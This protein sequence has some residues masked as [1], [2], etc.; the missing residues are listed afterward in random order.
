MKRVRRPG[1]PREELGGW[2]VRAQTEGKA[3]TAE[4]GLKWVR[5]KGFGVD[6]NAWQ[7]AWR[8]EG[9]KEKQVHRPGIPREELGGWVVRAQTEGG[10]KTAE[11]GLKWVQG[12]GFGVDTKAWLDAWRAEGGKEKQ[13]HR[14]GIPREELGRW[15]V[16]AQTEGGAK[17][18]AEG[19]EW[20]RGKGGGVD[21]N[22][23]QD[24]WRAEG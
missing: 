17:T 12:K 20:V 9:G 19:L 15:V 13:V 2:V 11:E 10:A 23:W 14:P 4:E 7:D 18:T 6:T 8:A 1:I 24:A 22:A 21:S 16:R 5:G 3:K